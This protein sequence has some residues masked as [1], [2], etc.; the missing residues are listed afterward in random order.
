MFKPT[1]KATI[2]IAITFVLIITIAVFIR[3]KYFN[4]VS[5]DSY[6]WTRVTAQAEWKPGYSFSA[7]AFNNK[8]WVF[9]KSDGNWLSDDG[10][11]WVRVQSN[12]DMPAASGYDSYVVFNNEVYAIGGTEDRSE[13][14]K[15]T[16]WKSSDGINWILLTQ[17]PEWSARVW[18]TL[19][20][21]NDKIWLIGGYDG[22]DRNDVWHSGDGVNWERATANAP[23]AGRCMHA[24]VIHDNK[25][26][27]MGGRSNMDGWWETQFNDVWYSTDGTNWMQ[28]TSS[29]GWSKRY[30]LASVSWDGKIWVM[31]GSRLFR[32]NEVWFSQD[33]TNWI[34]LGEASWTPR[35]SLATVVF[36]N[37]VWIMGGKEGGGIFTND[38]WHINPSPTQV[39]RTPRLKSRSS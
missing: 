37:R 7:L 24:S 22:D 39:A 19:V 3:A 10:K 34:E 21:L 2:A 29:A 18:Y 25:I 4:A 14:G 12:G 1:W 6:R 17:N 38:V 26:W 33:G 13:L 11:N 31:G 35:F 9:G 28:A 27:V 8:L 36:Q 30:G 15:K 16:V 20:V 5:V 32:N 23:W